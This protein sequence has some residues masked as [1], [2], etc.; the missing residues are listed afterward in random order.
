[1]DDASRKF[2]LKLKET[3]IIIGLKIMPGDEAFYFMHD[4]GELMGAVLT[5]VDDFFMVGTDEFLE[6]IRIGIAEALTVSKV[7][8]DRFRF[9]GWD[10]Q[11]YEDGVMVSMEEYG[12]S[13]KEIENIRRAHC[14]RK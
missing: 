9:T 12:N 10:V 7:E 13:L 2:W 4:R 6:K 8:R 11:N 3:L 5:H 1:M 14:Q